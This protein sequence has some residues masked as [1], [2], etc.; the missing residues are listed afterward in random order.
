MFH[1]QQLTVQ[2][3]KRMAEFLQ[4]RF[5]QNAAILDR[6]ATSLTV[7]RDHDEFIKLVNDIFQIGFSKGVD[8]CRDQFTALG[9]KVKLDYSGG[10]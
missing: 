6:V 4:E 2:T 7:P 3:K 1:Q 10:K 9:Y 5:Q 8:A